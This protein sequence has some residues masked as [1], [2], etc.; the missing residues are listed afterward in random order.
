MEYPKI[1]D[2]KDFI[3][4]SDKIKNLYGGIFSE[5]FNYEYVHEWR[6]YIYTR[7]NISKKLR[8]YI[9]EYLNEDITKIELISEYLKH[10]RK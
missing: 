9:W 5:K 7:T 3:L 8:G 2:F 1:K 4:N 10:K 6:E